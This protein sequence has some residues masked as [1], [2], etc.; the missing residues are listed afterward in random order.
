MY[1]LMLKI[2][3]GKT[4]P[5]GGMLKEMKEPCQ[6]LITMKLKWINIRLFY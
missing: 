5:C 4:E 6:K 1:I 3:Y 2:V